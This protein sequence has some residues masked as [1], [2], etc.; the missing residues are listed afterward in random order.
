MSANDMLLLWCFDY[1]VRRFAVDLLDRV[2]GM[3]LCGQHCNGCYL[4][5][6]TRHVVCPI[7][8]AYVLSRNWV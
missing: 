6:A 7:D 3:Y 5:A 1:V 8:A 2:I 4:H